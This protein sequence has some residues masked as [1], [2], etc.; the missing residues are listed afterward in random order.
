MDADG[1][2]I[3]SSPLTDKIVTW[4][5]LRIIYKLRIDVEMTICKDPGNYVRFTLLKKEEVLLWFC[6][7]Y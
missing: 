6:Y 2:V 7:K 3:L 4:Q 5:P 1:L